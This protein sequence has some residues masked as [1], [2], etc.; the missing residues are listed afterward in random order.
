MILA[1]SLLMTHF[2]AIL[3]RRQILVNGLRCS[4]EIHPYPML[5]LPDLN[6]PVLRRCH[7]YCFCNTIGLFR[8]RFGLLAIRY[9]FLFF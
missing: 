7:N 8:D 2:K 9:Y 1:P 6:T 5:T 3:V 4:L